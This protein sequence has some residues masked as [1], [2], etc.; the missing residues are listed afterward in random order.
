MDTPSYRDAWTHQKRWGSRQT[1]D[2]SLAIKKDESNGV[3]DRVKGKR[4]GQDKLQIRI[5]A[6]KKDKFDSDFVLDLIEENKDR[7]QDKRQI[8]IWPKKGGF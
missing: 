8:T 5:W 7:D 6:N 1:E 2:Q 4:W 3:F